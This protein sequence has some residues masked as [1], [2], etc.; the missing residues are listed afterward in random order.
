M[1]TKIILLTLFVLLSASATGQDLDMNETRK[2]GY[3]V[4]GHADIH[5]VPKAKASMDK[6]LALLPKG[7]T[8]HSR[9][10]AKSSFEG[11][12]QSVRLT[13]GNVK[14]N[15]HANEREQDRYDEYSGKYLKHYVWVTPDD[16]EKKSERDAIITL[17]K[18]IPHTQLEHINSSTP[19]YYILNFIIEK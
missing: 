1:K 17:S 13:N 5:R 11:W 15:A 16:K 4:Y 3:W 14:V 8:I 18:Q 7:W 12:Y 2:Q 19:A 9:M 10:T 6:F